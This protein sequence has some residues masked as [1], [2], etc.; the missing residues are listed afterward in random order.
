MVP[1]D[2]AGIG[3][4]QHDDAENDAVPG[5]RHKAVG[6]DKAQ[7]PAHAQPGADEREDQAHGKQRH[8]RHGQQRALLV[9]AVDARTDQRGHGQV[10]GVIGGGATAQAQQHPP[11][12]GGCT[13]T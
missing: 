11:D 1:V 9:E 6:G 2:D 4:H 10:K 7:Q 12:D 5:K 13:A 8:I 3:R